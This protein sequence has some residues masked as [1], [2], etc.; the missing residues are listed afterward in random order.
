MNEK[1]KHIVIF[2]TK[3]I[4]MHSRLLLLTIVSFFLLFT[5]PS[6]AQL[7]PPKAEAIYGG[8]INAITAIGLSSDSSRVF[9]TTESANSA[10]YMDV[11]QGSPGMK[12]TFGSFQLM[13]S[14]G[15]SAGFG[16]RI[17]QIAAH[18]KS[19]ALYFIH[20]GRLYGTTISSPI[21]YPVDSMGGVQ[22]LFITKETLL[23]IK[24]S[25]LFFG[26][27][28]ST[29]AYTPDPSGPIALPT[30]LSR[31]QMDIHPQNNCLYIFGGGNNPVLLR[32]NDR[33]DSLG[34]TKVINNL[35]VSSLNGVTDWSSFAIAPDGRL[36]A[37]GSNFMQKSIGIAINDSNWTHYASGFGGAP[38]KNISFGGDSGFYHVY[39]ANMAND[40]M[41][42][43]GKWHTFGIMGK[44]THPNDGPVWGD[45]TNFEV[46]YMTTDMGIGASHSQGK[47][48]YEVNE[49]IQAVQ[50][51]DFS[52]KLDKSTAW[53]ASKSG[54]RKVSTYRSTPSWT[55]PF[56]PMGDGSPYHA[57]CM[58]GQ[59]TNKIYAG[60]L[61]VYKSSDG[62]SSWQRVFSAENPPYNFPPAGNNSTG[63]AKIN[64]LAVCPYDTS[65]VMA[66]YG[67]EWGN[68]GGLFASTDG[69]ASW[70]QILL[71]AS[72]VGYDVNVMD[73]VFTIEGPDTIA[74]VAAKHNVS[75]PG[76][77]SI[78]RIKKSSSNWIPAQ[79]MGPTGT[80]T[81]SSIVA[82]ILDISKSP[83]GDTLVACGTDVGSMHPVS[84]Y[85][86]LKGS[87]VWTP[88][89]TTGF[90]FF[91]GKVAKAVTYGIDTV[92]VAVDEDIYFLP[93]GAASWTL[94]YSYP[95]GTQIQFLYY[96]E[97]LVG[98][99]TGIYGHQGQ[100]GPTFIDFN[101]W[102]NDWSQVQVYPNPVDQFPINIQLASPSTEAVEIRIFTT[103]G[104]LVYKEVFPAGDFF[105]LKN[106]DWIIGNGQY[107]LEINGGKL[108]YTGKVSIRQ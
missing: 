83:T 44:E 94:G 30:G 40:S 5:S 77:H 42:A 105:Q 62:A 58:A 18:G 69:G 20:E 31:P 64:A 78:Y 108:H 29:G 96:D 32:S 53:A 79:D 68:N 95:R 16:G 4:Q 104:K 86:D 6:I 33:F 27:L 65:I 61:R 36:F 89:T 100:A 60:N 17:E 15:S 54:I 101:D 67:I 41:G 46:V 66:A 82:S 48:I 26:T 90:P 92:Y 13:S 98:T 55:G 14:L 107:Y 47:K 63:A 10:F 12:P 8:R 59:D 2:W 91:S 75:V 72:T 51:N 3:N 37:A 50:V 57:V 11:K 28:D 39:Y 87:A 7:S 84:Y 25:D 24:G 93:V 1:I 80:S 70:D 21:N 35:N 38:G 22:S 71:S 81:G 45:P 103:M 43:S 74:Y 99:E 102:N 85:K 106:E 23:Y 9:V 73:I 49:G 34:M 52:M 76:G 88:H 56:F 97:L 19:S